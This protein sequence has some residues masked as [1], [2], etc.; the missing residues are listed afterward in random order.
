MIYST[1]V[2]CKKLLF[3]TYFLE[4]FLETLFKKHSCQMFQI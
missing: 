1:K 4:K 3:R 2:L